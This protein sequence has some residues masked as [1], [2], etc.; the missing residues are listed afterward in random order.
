MSIDFTRIEEI[1]VKDDDY[2]FSLIAFSNCHHVKDKTNTKTFD[3]I[4]KIVSHKCMQKCL[5]EIRFYTNAYMPY[6]KWDSTH[7]KLESFGITLV[8]GYCQF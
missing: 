5:K 3:L 6:Q 7:K 1:Y 2:N 8:M 4:D